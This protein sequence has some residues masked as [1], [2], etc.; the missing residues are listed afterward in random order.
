[1]PELHATA[2]CKPSIFMRLQSADL[3]LLAKKLQEK[4]QPDL[5]IFTDGAPS[6]ND[7]E[8]LVAQTSPSM[9]MKYRQTKIT[10]N[11]QIGL[12]HS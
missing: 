3:S 9:N 8:T 12:W 7:A 5:P 2:G 6:E 11:C 1:M 10:G 4:E